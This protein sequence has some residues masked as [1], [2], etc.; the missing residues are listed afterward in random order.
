MYSV[1]TLTPAEFLRTGSG[2]K[3]RCRSR[4]ADRS[5]SNQEAGTDEARSRVAGK[6]LPTPSARA[7]NATRS[8]DVNGGAVGWRWTT[9]NPSSDLPEKIGVDIVEPRA[10][11]TS[12]GSSVGVTG[13]SPRAAIGPHTECKDAR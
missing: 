8:L 3:L 7:A 9:R 4:A 12:P 13:I 6:M 10:K 5:C 11:S 1:T 2:K